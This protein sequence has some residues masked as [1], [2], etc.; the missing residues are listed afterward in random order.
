MPV[1]Q[2][3]DFSFFF[4]LWG[5]GVRGGNAVPVSQIQ[6]IVNFQLGEN[7]SQKLTVSLASSDKPKATH[8]LPVQELFSCTR[9]N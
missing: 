7:L 4:S 9:A 8:D 5:Y 6:R 3:I 2:N 1:K